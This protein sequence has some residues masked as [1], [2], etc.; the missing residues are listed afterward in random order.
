MTLILLDDSGEAADLAAFLTRLLRYDKA[1]VV[2]LR[3]HGEVLAVFGHPPF[4]VLAIRSARLA[5]TVEPLDAT[6][7]AGQLLDGLDEAAA[8][9]GMPPEVTGPPWTG[10]LPPRSGWRRTAALPLDTAHRELARG[11][12][13]FRARTERLDPDRRTRP[14][15]DR[16]ASDIWSTA[17]RVPVEVDLPLRVVH[18]AHALGFLRPVRVTG[19]ALQGSAPAP[20]LDDVLV[21]SSG[22]WL[23]ASTSYGSIAVRR[24]IGGGAGLALT[25]LR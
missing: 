18:A 12:A 16:I 9:I 6:V 15:L 1:A 21:Y 2:R 20:P 19:H 11:I 13:E 8:T 5:A 22:T 7:S 3:G 14:E 24:S 10:L 25:P 23:R 17:V 4:D